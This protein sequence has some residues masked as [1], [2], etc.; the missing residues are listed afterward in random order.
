ME[1]VVDESSNSIKLGEPLYN[2][3][4]GNVVQLEKSGDELIETDFTTK[5]QLYVHTIKKFKSS[6]NARNYTEVPDKVLKNPRI[7]IDD[8]VN[9][10]IE[11][12]EQRAAYSS[13]EIDAAWTLLRSELN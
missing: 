5:E 1:K 3:L 7:V 8:I 6:C 13:L 12:T 2:R 11:E 4:S 9:A 10:A